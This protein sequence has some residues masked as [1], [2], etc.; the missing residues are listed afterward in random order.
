MNFRWSESITYKFVQLYCEREC[1]W[2]YKHIN[3]NNRTAREAALEEMVIL[4]DLDDFDIAK[5]RKKIKNLRD[6]YIQELIKIDKSRRKTSNEERVY[7]PQMKWF[8]LM[9]RYLKDIDKR[10]RRALHVSLYIYTKY[11][12]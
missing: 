2:D 7:V 9:H 5:A 11:V 1:L 8:S 10:N 3:Y 6:T 4:M 12:R